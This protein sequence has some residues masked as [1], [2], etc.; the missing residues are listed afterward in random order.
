MRKIDAYTIIL[1]A[2][3]DLAFIA[4]NRDRDLFCLAVPGSVP[5]GFLNDAKEGQFVD[6]G[7]GFL[8]SASNQVGGQMVR[9]AEI[10][11]QL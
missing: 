9:V 7:Q 6:R 4:G 5:H 8:R 11:H 1:N 3:A 10:G 2:G